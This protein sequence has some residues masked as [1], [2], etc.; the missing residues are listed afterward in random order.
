[1]NQIRIASYAPLLDTVRSDF[2]SARKAQTPPVALGLNDAPTLDSY[3]RSI[4]VEVFPDLW[5]P[6]HAS[7]AIGFDVPKAMNRAGSI[8]AVQD[9]HL[10]TAKVRVTGKLDGQVLVVFGE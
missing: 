8:R 10:K 6:A 7:E 5:Q 2:S 9:D 1:M 3:V 4:M